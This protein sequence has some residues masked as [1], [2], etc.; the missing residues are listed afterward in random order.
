[1]AMNF[2]AYSTFI[3]PAHHSRF[4]Y[5]GLIFP[6]FLVLNMLFVAFWL[7]FKK[8][9]ALLPLA[10]FIL[11]APSIRTY[12]PLNYRKESP[13]G[14]IKFISY[15]VMNFAG[16][17]E[18]EGNCTTNPI[19]RY[20]LNSDADIICMQEGDFSSLPGLKDSLTSKYP[21]FVESSGIMGQTNTCVSKF[22][23]LD[24]Q[25]V[26][27]ESTSNRSHAY[28]LLV[29]NDT[30][31]VV[32]NH[33][34][35]YQLQAEDKANYK[36]IIVNPKNDSTVVMYGNLMNKLKVKNVVRSLQADRVAEYVDSVPCKYK[37]VCGDFNDPSLSYTHHRLTRN[38]NDAFTRSGFGAG[39]SYNRSG[40]YFRIDNILVS[41]NIDTYMTKVDNSIDESDHYPIISYLI[42]NEK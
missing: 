27:Y 37:I 17:M 23:V 40:M 2:C 18:E 35:S 15:N 11:C 3:H 22:P 10:G 30:V 1:M 14:A 33:L 5:F 4:S 29:G 36:E 21:Y 6:A 9:L 42:L 28:K 34:E 13:P 26:C 8:K 12:F 24:V 25:E 41:P 16:G 7:C 20:L 38:L 39:I 19:V 31:L 32:N